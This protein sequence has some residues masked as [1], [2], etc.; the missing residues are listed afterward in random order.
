M[1]IKYPDLVSYDAII[2]SI[3]SFLQKT[4][5]RFLRKKRFILKKH[6]FLKR[7]VF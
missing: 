5:F 2:K 4:I 3:K 1:Q 7:Y 6:I